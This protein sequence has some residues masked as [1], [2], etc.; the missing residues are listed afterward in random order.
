MKKKIESLEQILEREKQREAVNTKALREEIR[1]KDSELNMFKSKINKKDDDLEEIL[2][3]IDKMRNE[4]KSE[5]TVEYD[6]FQTVQR[7][8]TD[9]QDNNRQL[10]SRAEK[11][12]ASLRHNV[13]KMQEYQAEIKL[14]AADIQNMGNT[15]EDQRKEIQGYTIAVENFNTKVTLVEEQNT[16]LMYEIEMH[17]KNADQMT[18][19]GSDWKEQVQTLEDRLKD[20]RHEIGLKAKEMDGLTNQVGQK[21]TMIIQLKQESSLYQ[22]AVEDSKEQIT[23]LEH[24]IA[25]LKNEV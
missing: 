9:Q 5:M 13:S 20:Q 1:T 19:E 17:K 2:S 24:A 22:S 11:L 23:D 6:R 7:E 10:E 4:H 25:N 16:A 14:K 3:K 12:E 18:M 8:L 15:I 21:D